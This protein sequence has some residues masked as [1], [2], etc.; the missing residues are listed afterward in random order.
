M[1]NHYPY[2]VVLAKAYTGQKWICLC[3]M[4]ATEKS[5]VEGPK[6]PLTAKSRH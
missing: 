5:P 3:K 4:K 6:L 1:F 2:S